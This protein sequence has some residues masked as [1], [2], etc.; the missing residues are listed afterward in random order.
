M[1]NK[2]NIFLYL[3]HKSPYIYE[4]S[5]NALYLGEA[6]GQNT[7]GQIPWARLLLIPCKKTLLTLILVLIKIRMEHGIDPWYSRGM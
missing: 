1:V 5:K 7:M 3:L 6:Y 4:H 2:W